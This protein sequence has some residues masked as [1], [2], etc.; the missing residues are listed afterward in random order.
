MSSRLPRVRPIPDDIF[1]NTDE[2]RRE[3]AKQFLKD[4]VRPG[5][6]DNKPENEKES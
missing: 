1:N 3:W 4:F 5:E 6:S 2:E